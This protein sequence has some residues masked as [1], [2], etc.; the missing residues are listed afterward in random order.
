MKVIGND[1]SNQFWEHHHQQR[2]RLP[3]N[4]EREIREQF[5]RAKYQTKSWIPR[6][7]TSVI[8][9]LNIALCENVKTD[10]VMETVRL[11]AY[12]CDVS[13]CTYAHICVYIRVLPQYPPPPPS[14]LSL[15]LPYLI[16]KTLS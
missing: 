2:E 14:T 13:V 15:A 10:N 3:A 5:I 7:N 16:V 12:G 6:R 9:V 11:F 4:V 8:E 1:L